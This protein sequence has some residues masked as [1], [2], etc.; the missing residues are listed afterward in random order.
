MPTTIAWT[1][2]RVAEAESLTKGRTWAGV[3]EELSRRWGE[4]VGPAAAKDAVNA[5]RRGARGTASH[6]ASPDAAYNRSAANDSGV[7]DAELAAIAAKVNASN[8]KPRDVVGQ[9][10]KRTLIIPDVHVPYH[11]RRAWALML[12]AAR[13]VKPE[14]I[15]VLGDLLDFH[16]VSSH[17]KRPDQ[18]VSLS[19]ELDGG[20]DAL[21]QLDA[22][23]AAEK[24]CLSGNHETRLE[25]LLMARAPEV[26]GLVPKVST[27]LRLAERGWRHIDY[28][29]HVTI[30]GVTFTHDTDQAGLHANLHAR[31]KV[32][33]DACI[34]H[35]HRL[36]QTYLGDRDGVP[37]SGTML[38]W[39]GDASA[40]DY[41]SSLSVRHEWTLAF[42]LGTTLPGGKMV[43]QPVPIIGYQCT[44]DGLLVSD[45]A[46]EA[47][48]AAA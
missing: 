16:C 5:R 48:K 23:G 39:L 37:C 14:R 33:G 47:G 9:R 18:T 34:G 36:S 1:A 44:V 25:R 27:L 21:D 30:D 29:Q 12:R 46:I 3:A 15:V 17:P 43:V 26:F 22:L 11:D 8:A 35:T 4:P 38:G 2:E 40:I 24:V 28:R 42:G 31:R 6:A 19:T 32:E 7:S 10:L 41:R 20:N 45:G 13:L